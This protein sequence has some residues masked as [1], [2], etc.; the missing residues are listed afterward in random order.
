[1]N[2]VRGGQLFQSILVTEIIAFKYHSMRCFF[3]KR[4]LVISRYEVFGRRTLVAFV[5][6]LGENGVGA[7][8]AMQIKMVDF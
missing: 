1:M 6:C 4:W 8:D 7:N 5:R 3:S 2:G